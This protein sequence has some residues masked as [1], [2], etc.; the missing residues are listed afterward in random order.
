LDEVLYQGDKIKPGVEQSNLKF[1]YKQMVRIYLELD[2]HDFDK[3]RVLSIS[4]DHQPCHVECAPLTLKMNDGQRMT[5]IDLYG[6]IILSIYALIRRLHHTSRN[7][8][9]SIPG[10]F[11]RI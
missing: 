3:V 7:L 2:S 10:F 4:P 9:T 1:I 11:A 8:S 5:G 6:R